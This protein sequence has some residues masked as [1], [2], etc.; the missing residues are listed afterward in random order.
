MSG[1]LERS[2][3][4]DGARSAED[5]QA[6]ALLLCDVHEVAAG[7]GEDNVIYLAEQV[8]ELVYQDVDL[9]LG[10]ECLDREAKRHSLVIL[11][12]ISHTG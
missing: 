12:D 8:Q 10:V 1:W 11:A 9:I 3:R 4:R 2:E 7:F 5:L 6:E